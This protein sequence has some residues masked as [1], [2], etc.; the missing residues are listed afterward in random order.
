[1]YV[2]NEGPCTTGHAWRRLQHRVSGNKYL[3]NVCGFFGYEKGGS[4]AQSMWHIETLWFAVSEVFED[5]E[6]PDVATV[7]TGLHESL[8]YAEPDWRAEQVERGTYQQRFHERNVWR[9]SLDTLPKD[10]SKSL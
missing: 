10:R 1:M 8:P 5:S 2:L 7:N 9:T 4:I 6:L 3:C